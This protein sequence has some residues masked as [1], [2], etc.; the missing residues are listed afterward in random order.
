MKKLLFAACLFFIA[1]LCNCTSEVVDLKEEVS[2]S[3]RGDTRADVVVWEAQPGAIDVPLGK[4][5]TLGLDGT[6]TY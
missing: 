6:V 4:E 3:T 2:A 1:S 5:F